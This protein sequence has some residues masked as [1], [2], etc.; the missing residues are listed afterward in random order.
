MG[1]IKSAPEINTLAEKEPT[2]GGVYFVTAFAGLLAPYW[3]TSAGGMLIGAFDFDSQSSSALSFRP[4]SRT[5]RRSLVLTTY[6]SFLISLHLLS[7]HPTPLHYI[8][9]SRS[10]RTPPTSLAQPWRP[11]HT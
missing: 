8:Q 5:N 2:S 1:I 11:C 9:V 4:S 7:F 6:L 10:I 3:D